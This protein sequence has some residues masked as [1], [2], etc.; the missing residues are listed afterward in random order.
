MDNSFEVLVD[1]FSKFPGIGPKTAQRMTRHLLDDM[2]MHEVVNLA[3]SMVNVKHNVRSC[4]VCFCITE[5]EVCKVCSDKSRDLSVMCV[6]EDPFVVDSFEKIGFHGLYHCLQ[7]GIDPQSGVGPDDIRIDDLISRLDCGK[8]DEVILAMNPNIIGDT[9]SMYISRL[10]SD[11]GIMV[12]RI[13][14]GLPVGSEI[15][16]A[17]QVTLTCSMEGRSI[18]E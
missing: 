9:T 3:K 7:G 16:N 8:V 6:V 5:D 18:M 2:D 10:I 1:N 17:D 14:F 13:A 12:S 4:N 15:Q 11:M